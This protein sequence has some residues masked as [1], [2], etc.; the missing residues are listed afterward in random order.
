[1]AKEFMKKRFIRNPRKNPP[2][3]TRGLNFIL[4]F[5]ILLIL[6]P[7]IHSI[8]VSGVGAEKSPPAEQIAA[9]NQ[10]ADESIE[11]NRRL[12][13]YAATIRELENEKRNLEQIIS[14]REGELRAANTRLSESERSLT[15][16]QR[17]NSS[18]NAERD[19]L[20]RRVT[21]LEQQLETV[22]ALLQN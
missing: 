7:G 21:D 8:I 9:M 22:R 16:R 17:E 12:A 5:L 13:E 4:F 18:L 2:R 14:Q 10:G 3:K 11:Q 19:R 20:Q 15:D 1:M 6:A